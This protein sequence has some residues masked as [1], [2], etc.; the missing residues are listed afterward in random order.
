MQENCRY[1][2]TLYIIS[3]DPDLRFEVTLDFLTIPKI[4]KRGKNYLCK[5]YREYFKTWVNEFFR[6]K[7]FL[8]NFGL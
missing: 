8:V 7:I 2:S 3:T 4:D 5:Y 1:Y 6:D